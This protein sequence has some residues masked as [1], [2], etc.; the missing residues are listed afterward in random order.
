MELTRRSNNNNS[1][2]G[3]IRGVNLNTWGPLINRL[4][5]MAIKYAQSGQSANSG[6][7]GVGD[8]SFSSQRTT[9][10]NPRRRRKA[11]GAGA[12]DREGIPNVVN[13]KVHNVTIRGSYM[14]SGPGNGAKRFYLGNL[15]D[16]ANDL[17]L[18]NSISLPE[19]NFLK[20]FGC[21]K[22]QRVAVNFTSCAGPNNGGYHIAVAR[23]TVLDMEYITPFEIGK[24]PGQVQSALSKPIN[25]TFVPSHHD[26]VVHYN[27]SFES[28]VNDRVAGTIL[29]YN[30]VTGGLAAGSPLAV[31]SFTL[32]MAVWNS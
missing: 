16:V 15:T 31:C 1:G 28:D 27:E 29:Y 32:N 2:L 30:A 13:V 19:L 12:L 14:L 22:Y 11:N 20:A 17:L 25:I 18:T 24:I 8:A 21:W 7:S 9:T 10:R 6:Q 5:K 3:A 4:T 26:G 23:S